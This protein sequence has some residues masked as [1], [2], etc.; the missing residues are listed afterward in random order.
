MSKGFPNL[1]GQ[2]KYPVWNRGNAFWAPVSTNGNCASVSWRCVKAFGF[3]GLFFNYDVYVHGQRPKRADEFGGRFRAHNTSLIVETVTL[4]G[5]SLGSPLP[6]QNDSTRRASRIR[7]ADY[8][9][10]RGCRFVERLIGTRIPWT[11]RLSTIRYIA[12]T[13]LVRFNL[14]AV[15]VEITSQLPSFLGSSLK[16]HWY[17]AWNRKAPVSI[18]WIRQKMLR[19]AL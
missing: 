8:T 5:R 9:P 7:G 18:K 16:L 15:L 12:G 10:R 14:T 13:E 6:S 4:R 1:R 17:C 11:L 19:R 2:P 3:S